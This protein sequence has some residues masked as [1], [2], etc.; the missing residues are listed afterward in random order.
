MN[1][2]RRRRGWEWEEEE[3]FLLLHVRD[4]NCELWLCQLLRP[5][6]THKSN[7]KI[8]SYFVI[9][10]MTKLI[11]CQL[12]PHCPWKNK[13]FTSDYI[14]RILCPE[15][16][17][18]ELSSCLKGLTFLMHAIAFEG[19]ANNAITNCGRPKYFALVSYSLSTV[20]FVKFRTFDW[21]KSL[22]PS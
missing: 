8:L 3:D 11:Y 18:K 7:K 17:W 9:E 13:V 21:E 12:C 10:N 4:V 20:R 2:W 22:Q 5:M 15:L 19:N 6:Q 1:G 16:R 14:L